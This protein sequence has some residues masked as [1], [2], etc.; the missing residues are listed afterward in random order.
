MRSSS[1]F[2][3]L[4]RAGRAASLIA[5]L[6]LAVRCAAPAQNSD[7]QKALASPSTQ[8]T[9]PRSS[10]TSSSEP[11]S[12]AQKSVPAKPASPPSTAQGI[13]VDAAALLLTPI[14]LP[15]MAAWILVCLPV[16]VTG[17][18]DC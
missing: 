13:A 14:A 3:N 15:F 11:K 12:D 1:M 8:E 10:E 6:P 7:S 5:A 18:G 16:V 9:R 4:I 17:K 2:E